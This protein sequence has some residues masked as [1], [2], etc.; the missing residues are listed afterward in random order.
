MKKI[1]QDNRLIISGCILFLSFILSGIVAHG[2]G[3]PISIRAIQ[4]ENQQSE[5]SYFDLRMIPEQKQTIEL[6]VTN[7]SDKEVS[8]HIQTNP[9]QTNDNGVIIYSESDK[10]NRLKSREISFSDIASVDTFVTVQGNG[11]V[12][13]P[14]ELTMPDTWYDGEIIGGIYITLSEPKETESEVKSKSTMAVINKF[15]YSVGVRLTE[16]A[17]PISSDIKLRSINPAQVV[18][19]NVLKV[20]LENPTTTLIDNLSYEAKIY[21][22]GK[23]ELY[24]EANVS[25][26]RMAP[27]S[28]FDL[29]IP[30]GNQKFD[31]GDYRLELMAYSKDTNQTWKWKKNFT[32]TDKKANQLNEV[33]L[34]LE[35]PEFPWITIISGILIV[36]V[37]LLLFLILRLKK[38]MLS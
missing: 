11:T 33:A 15:E 24:R 32:I 14:I 30:W 27:T 37:L 10:D 23:N 1:I 8:V 36:C 25:N 22:K 35:Q 26:Y 9:A 19:R 2:D 16:T 7:A 4:P 3:M 5:V 31:S 38:K 34:G 13:V 20:T 17:T 29:G 28:A 12:Q 6:A 18:R 21:K